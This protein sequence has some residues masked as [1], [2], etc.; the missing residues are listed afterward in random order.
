MLQYPTNVSPENVAKPADATQMKFTFNGDRLSY[1]NIRATDM[2]TNNRFT[3]EYKAEDMTENNHLPRYNGEEIIMSM[4]AQGLENGHDYVWQVLLAQRDLAGENPLYDIPVCRGTIQGTS[5]TMIYIDK[6]LPLYEWNYNGN[7][8]R[9][10]PIMDDDIVRAGLIIEI[11][12]E[13]RFIEWY[14]TGVPYGEAGNYAGIANVDELF[15][16]TPSAGDRYQIFANY[17]ISPQYYF[18]NRATPSLTLNL[19]WEREGGEAIKSNLALHLTGSYGQEQSTPI[20]YYTV[21]LYAFEGN[22]VDSPSAILHPIAESE[23]IFSQRID[24]IFEDALVGLNP[25]NGEDMTYMNYRA[26]VELVT[27][28]NVTYAGYTSMRIEGID[29]YAPDSRRFTWLPINYYG[30]NACRDSGVGLQGVIA[31]YYRTNL[32]TNETVMLKA[33]ERLYD[34][35]AS[36]KGNYRYTTVFYDAQTAQFYIKST[37]HFDVSTNFDGYFITELIPAGENKYQVGDTWKFICEID[38]TTVS[39]NLDIV[40]QVGYAQYPTVSST[41]LNYLSGTFSS[42]IGYFDCCQKKYV[43]NIALVEAW[44]KF[45]SKPHPYLLKTQ[46]GDVLMVN[47]TESPKIEYQED[48]RKIPTRLTFSW[49]ECGNVN[50]YYMEFSS[51]DFDYEKVKCSKGAPA[52]KDWYDPTD[53]SDYIYY[54]DRSQ[55][56]IVRYIGNS[57]NLAIPET[58]GGYPVTTIGATAFYDTEIYSVWLPSTVKIVE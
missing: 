7:Q 24:Y 2:A 8:Q 19:D 34:F 21:K 26:I 3:I 55:A 50:D 48:Y 9:Y 54:T 35:K 43:D 38:N 25:W 52:D 22:N 46:K 4:N 37:E 57:H 56:T 33:Q 28:D 23:K 13:R 44:R 16:E 51:G 58:L 45:I 18:M 11:N 53:E 5:D 14:K 10:E 20:K 12:G 27:Q 30:C 6:N 32:D 1:Y 15:T 17:L 36:T 31:R 41:E 47:I 49:A 39:Q 29:D 40:Q 42:Y